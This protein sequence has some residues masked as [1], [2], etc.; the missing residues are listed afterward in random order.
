MCTCT[1]LRIRAGIRESLQL[2]LD[3]VW[4][5]QRAKDVQYTYIVFRGI[6]PSMNARVNG[7]NV[8]LV[9]LLVHEEKFSKS[10]T[11]A[12]EVAENA[13]YRFIG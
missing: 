11:S 4:V 8:N 13:E 5:F 10:T 1:P 2:P 7:E 12:A 3:Q 6:S 9:L